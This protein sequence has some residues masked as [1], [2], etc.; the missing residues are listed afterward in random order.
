[1][2][3]DDYVLKLWNMGLSVMQVAI[4]YKKYNNKLAKS[5]K[6]RDKINLQQSLQYIEPILFKYEIN[7]MKNM[8]GS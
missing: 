6:Y 3:D 2:K 5:F 8:E 4:E 1:M 7:R